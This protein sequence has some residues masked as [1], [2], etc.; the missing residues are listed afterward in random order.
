MKIAFDAVA[1]HFDRARLRESRR[2]FDEQM[3]VAEERGQHS[4]QEMLLTD[5]ELLEV[6]LE[7]LEFFLQGHGLPSNLKAGHFKP[8]F[9]GR[10]TRRRFD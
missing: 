4:A 8:G 9:S 3:A 2:A 7:P 5:D 1:Q 10:A 6:R